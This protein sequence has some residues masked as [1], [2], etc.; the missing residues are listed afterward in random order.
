MKEDVKIADNKAL[1]I[2]GRSV[3]SDYLEQ[4]S[5][6]DTAFQAWNTL[7]QIYEGDSVSNLMT[8]RS[9]FYALK[10]EESDDM[11]LFLGK[12]EK[13]KRNHGTRTDYQS[14]V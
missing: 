2:I 3:K 9:E 12:L 14:N 4:L 6:S 11:V 13:C 10:M 8:V 5:S 7:K 1:G